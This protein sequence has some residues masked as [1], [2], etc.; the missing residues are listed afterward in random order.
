MY[1]LPRNEPEERGACLGRIPRGPD[2]AAG[3]CV[4]EEEWLRNRGFVDTPAL[5]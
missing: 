1:Q 5:E 4:V 3:F 2:Q